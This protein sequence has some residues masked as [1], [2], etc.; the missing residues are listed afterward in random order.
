LENLPY[1]RAL[2]ALKAFAKL[3]KNRKVEE[4]HR[5]SMCRA[6]RADFEQWVQ[7]GRAADIA[8]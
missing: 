5:Q 1:F 3:L 7:F 2:F 6:Y 4:A 8:A